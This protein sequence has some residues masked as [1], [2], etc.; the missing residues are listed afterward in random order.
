MRKMMYANNDIANN[1]IMGKFPQYQECQ[2]DQIE[3]IVLKNDAKTMLLIS[4]YA[5]IT[6][7][8]C[9]IKKVNQDLCFLEWNNSLAREI[10]QQ[11]CKRAFS[12]VEKSVL[13]S[14][15]VTDVDVTVE[16]YVF[17]LSEEEVRVFMPSTDL[18]KAKPTQYAL[19]KGARLGWTDD[20]REFTSWWIMPQVNEMKLGHIFSPNGIEYG[21]H[22]EIFPKAVFQSGDIQYHGRNVYHEDFTLRPC[23]LVDCEKFKSIQGNQMRSPADLDKNH[24]TKAKESGGVAYSLEYMMSWENQIMEKRPGGRSSTHD[25]SLQKWRMRIQLDNRGIWFLSVFINDDG[26]FDKFS[27]DKETAED[28]H[29]EFRD[30]GGVRNSIY[31]SGDENKYLA[32]VLIRYVE[33]YGGSSLLNRIQPFITAQFHY[34]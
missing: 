27:L 24:A 31:M 33:Q 17:L 20:T 9:N 6:T 2:E 30:E 18:R 16:D 13:V 7:G 15:Q 25:V 1:I 34:D 12:S 10:C 32:E 19:E 3:W 8:Y 29:Y 4:K 22:K 28:S 21:K 26:T 11:F 23:I 14:R 5:L